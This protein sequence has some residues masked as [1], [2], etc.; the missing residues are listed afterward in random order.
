MEIDRSTLG[1]KRPTGCQVRRYTGDTIGGLTLPQVAK[2]AREKYGV[3]I[4]VRVGSNVCTPD[5]AAGQLRRGRSFGLQGNTVALL[6]TAFRSTTSGVNHFVLVN[7]GRGW[8]KT[9]SGLWRPKEALVYDPAADRRRAGIADGP[10]WWPWQVVLNF[11]A[12][13]KPWGDRDERVLGYGKFYAGLG[14]DTEPHVHLH[15]TGSVRT[16]PFPD[17]M[18]IKSPTTGRRV[19]V[20]K[21]P[22]TAY[23][24]VTT[25]AS[26]TH[27]AAYQVT[28]QGQ[29]LAGSRVWYGDHNGA[30]WVHS[31]GIHT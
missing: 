30:R 29:E 1:R 4:E 27:F 25:L 22:S 3:A 21:G 7:E 13:L 24:V 28:R 5:Y 12:N 6:K 14:P 19:N 23:A 8:Y 17:A 11:A 10:D 2:V 16:S 18:T 20:R 9:G 26:G 15:Y 31:S